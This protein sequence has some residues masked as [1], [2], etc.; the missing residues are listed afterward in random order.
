MEGE[1]NYNCVPGSAGL[2]NGSPVPSTKENFALELLGDPVVKY[3]CS[4]T[5]D[6]GLT[7]DGGTMAVFSVLYSYPCGLFILYIVIPR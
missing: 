1:L 6:A 2:I 5:G 7:P 3:P 4:N